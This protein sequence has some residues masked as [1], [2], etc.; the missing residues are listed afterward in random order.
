MID[1]NDDGWGDLFL[2]SKEDTEESS[3]DDDDSDK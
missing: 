2:T 1:E 3:G